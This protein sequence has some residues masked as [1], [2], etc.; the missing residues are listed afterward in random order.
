MEAPLI[1]EYLPI[2]Q[3][4]QLV[5]P[6]VEIYFPDPHRT[7]VDCTVAPTFVEYF[8]VAHEVQFVAAAVEAY[9]PAVQLI[10]DITF[11]NIAN[12]EIIAI[13]FK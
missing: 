1:D 2:P 12:E 13:H 5:E 3:R 6:T 9:V 8:P 10:V 4:V 11:G 7:H